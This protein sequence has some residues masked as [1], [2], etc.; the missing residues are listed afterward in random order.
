MN[1]GHKIPVICLDPSS[2]A[3][4]KLFNPND[5]SGESKAIIQSCSTE[6]SVL[7]FECNNI[8]KL[9]IN[10]YQQCLS[11]FES[12]KQ[13]WK[14]P[15]DTL[16]KTVCYAQ[17]PE[18]HVFI[19]AFFSSL[20]GLLDL[21]VQ[22]LHSEKIV[23][24]KLDGFHRKKDVYGGSV[25]N[26]LSH[27]ASSGKKQVAQKVIKLIETHK[28]NWINDVIRSR[29]LL[30]HPTKGIHQ[31]MFEMILEIHDDSLILKRVVP[32]SVGNQSID[33]YVRTHICNIE[34]FC[35]SFI[36]NL[37]TP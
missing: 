30:V 3:A 6:L 24:A 22:L 16:H 32:P 12:L 10:P 5:W 23:N 13:S 27:N 18:I 15:K 20:K 17:I 19:K 9:C 1:N 7:H 33:N 4:F 21:I 29:D 37:V 8:E 25:I 28:D 26:A 36:L 11:H 35:K 31:L 14:K 2:M 34:E